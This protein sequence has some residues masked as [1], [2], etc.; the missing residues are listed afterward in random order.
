MLAFGH[1]GNIETFVE[2]KATSDAAIGCRL[3]AS[4]RTSV[5]E[6]LKVNPHRLGTTAEAL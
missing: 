1:D 6:L 2:I 4:S 3:V 5:L